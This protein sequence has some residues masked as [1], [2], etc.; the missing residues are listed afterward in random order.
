MSLH[1]EC[2]PYNGYQVILVHS[3]DQTG[4]LYTNS[5][6]CSASAT[7]HIKKSGIYYL[8]VIKIQGNRGIT[9][10]ELLHIENVT[11]KGKDHTPS[12][13]SSITTPPD[14]SEGKVYICL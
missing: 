7:I 8:T 5:S 1:C 2:P 3:S 11:F 10:S 13:K 6:K 14:R 12:G 4:T 9:Q